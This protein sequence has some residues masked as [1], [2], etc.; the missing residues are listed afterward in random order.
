MR[1][2]SQSFVQPVAFLC[3]MSASKASHLDAPR[4]RGAIA[5]SDEPN[6]RYRHLFYNKEDRAGRW[7]ALSIDRIPIRCIWLILQLYRYDQPL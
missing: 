6:P 3:M 1:E 5:S 4:A 2:N 7:R